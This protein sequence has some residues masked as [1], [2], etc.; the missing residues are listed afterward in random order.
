VEDVRRTRSLT[1]EQAVAYLEQQPMPSRRAAA[2]SAALRMVLHRN[3]ATPAARPPNPL[4]IPD[5][6][7]LVA[8]SLRRNNAARFAAVSRAARNGVRRVADQLHLCLVT[9]DEKWVETSYHTREKPYRGKEWR[10]GWG[11]IPN[12]TFY[13]LHHDLYPNRFISKVPAKFLTKYPTKQHLLAALEEYLA[14]LKRIP[15]FIWITLDAY[16]NG[17][18]WLYRGVKLLCKEP[19]ALREILAWIKLVHNQ[20]MR[21]PSFADVIMELAGRTSYGVLYAVLAVYNILGPA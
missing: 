3:R 8:S 14:P 17:M 19:T 10:Q 2:R 11:T 21:S 9:D 1:V 20:H 12:I 6:A 5:I 13:P 4:D 7:S 15:G 18:V 16:K